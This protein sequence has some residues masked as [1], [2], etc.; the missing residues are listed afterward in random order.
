M[1]EEGNSDGW[2]VPVIFTSSIRKERS[3]RVLAILA[4]SIRR[5]EFLVRLETLMNLI[6]RK[7]R[8]EE[9]FEL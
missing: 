8:V 2:R 3:G 4:N 7:T 9:R 1:E 6:R 5:K